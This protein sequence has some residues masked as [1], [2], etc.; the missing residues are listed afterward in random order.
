MS[1]GQKTEVRVARAKRLIAILEREQR[2]I[3]KQLERCQDKT[4]RDRLR[5]EWTRLHVRMFDI[6][7]A[8]LE[9]E[10]H[11]KAVK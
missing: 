10:Q 11:L 1:N 3:L 6:G 5:S 4:E 7:I 2:P 9:G 8:A